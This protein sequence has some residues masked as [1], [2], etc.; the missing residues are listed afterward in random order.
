MNST[1]KILEQHDRVDPS[2][3]DVWKLLEKQ[4]LQDQWPQ[5][6]LERSINSFDTQ[7]PRAESIP[8][9]IATTMS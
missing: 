8:L 1:G 6:N 4:N 5:G 9:R 7:V 2:E 3:K